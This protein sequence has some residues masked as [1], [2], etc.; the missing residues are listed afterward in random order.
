V[1]LATARALKDLRPLVL[2]DHALKLQQQLVFRRIALRRLDEYRLN[3]TAGELFREQDLV[4]VFAAEPV[5]R[6]D[7]DGLKLALGSE[8]AQAL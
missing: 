6:V 2:G 5:G 1:A 8:I 7:E 4:G 3:A